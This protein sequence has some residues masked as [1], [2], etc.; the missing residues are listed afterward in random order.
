MQK[1]AHL[2]ASARRHFGVEAPSLGHEKA[3]LQEL[4]VIAEPLLEPLQRGAGLPIFASV[5]LISGG[6]ECPFAVRDER[7]FVAARAR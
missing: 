7:L 6:V 5:E 2:F 3:R 4:G 1:L